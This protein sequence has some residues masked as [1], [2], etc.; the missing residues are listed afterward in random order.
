[1][2]DKEEMWVIPVVFFISKKDPLNAFE[3][4]HND[5]MPHLQKAQ[6]ENPDMSFIFSPGDMEHHVH[7]K[8]ESCISKPISKEDVDLILKLSLPPRILTKLEELERQ[9]KEQEPCH[10]CEGKGKIR[11]GKH[12]VIEVRKCPDCEGSGKNKHTHG[13]K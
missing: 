5:I 4:F 10:R 12:P 7:V 9:R 2:S 1:M 8:G 13:G 6:L 11:E 3:L